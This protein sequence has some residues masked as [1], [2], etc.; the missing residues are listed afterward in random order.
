MTFRDRADAGRRLAGLVVALALDDPVVLGMARGGVPVAAELAGALGAPLDVL[1]VRKLGYPA[2]PELA[3]G[4]IGEGG[5]RVL[6]DHVI[7][8]L[9]V[10]SSV[11]ERVAAVEEAELE[12]RLVAYRDGRRAVSVAGRAVV[13]VD[14]GL[15]TGATARAAVAVVRRRGAAR[16]IVAAPVAPP[17]V[18]RAL[19]AEA[20]DVVCVEVSERFFGIGQWY[21]DFHQVTDDEVRRI[22]AD[23]P[24]RAAD[25]AP[26][27]AP[28]GVQGSVAGSA[29]G[30]ASV[31]GAPA[32]AR[33]LAVQV[34]ADGLALPGDLVV[35]ADAGGL[36]VFA[37]GSG[38]SRSS[39]RNQA[40]ARTLHRNGLA[41]LLFDLL[42]PEEAADRANVFDIG[43]L[44]RRLVAATEWAGSRPE[45]GALPVGLFGASTGAG[46]AVVAAAHL[47]SRV[48]AVV[49][50][51]GRPDLALPADLRAVRAPTLLVVGSKDTAVL[52]GNRW[53]LGLLPDAALEVVDGATHL[54]EEP[55][56]L[57]EVA[58]LASAWFVDHLVGAPPPAR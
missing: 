10:P 21:D 55:G 46:A 39:P 33:E 47:S 51:G 6:N 5:V 4:A 50:R 15:A 2:Q 20:D 58:R 11:I 41:T 57:E 29:P 35:P 16:V 19:A 14:D 28:G 27:G 18:V 42:T 52:E 38:S 17:A 53:A 56:T 30:S 22:L 8:Q 12:R 34:A 1:V 32:A 9:D 7:A 40:V 44:G 24:G 43:L 36:V 48:G 26:G 13:V 54:F 49:S 25:G 31:A 23:A 37:H 45:L 3:M